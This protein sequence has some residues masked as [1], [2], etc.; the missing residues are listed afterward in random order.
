M[1]RF[2]DTVLSKDFWL[3][4]YAL[5]SYIAFLS[6]VLHLIAKR[7]YGFFRDELY[8]I[9][10][11]NHLDFGYVDQPPLSIFLL[12]IVRMEL[13][14]SLIAVRILP[15]L[16]GAF[17]VFFTGLIARELGGRRFALFLDCSTGSAGLD[18]SIISK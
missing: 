14:D 6:L 2:R 4:D 8:Y 10:C 5:I 11:S 16:S 15:V 18:T 13:G 12:K 17:I 7:G 9:A 1:K 3:S